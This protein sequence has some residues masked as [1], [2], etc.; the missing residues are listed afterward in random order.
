LFLYL[1][2]PRR[3]RLHQ[4]Y[5]PLSITLQETVRDSRCPSFV[6]GERIGPVVEPSAR[7]SLGQMRRN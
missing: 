7:L 6:D 2:Q 1:L 4:V 3:E 5:Q